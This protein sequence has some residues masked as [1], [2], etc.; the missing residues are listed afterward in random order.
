MAAAVVCQNK[1][2]TGNEGRKTEGGGR[3]HSGEAPQRSGPNKD[4]LHGA[5]FSMYTLAALGFFLHIPRTPMVLEVQ[6]LR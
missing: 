4:Q 3:T 1:K 5:L 6:L 2:T